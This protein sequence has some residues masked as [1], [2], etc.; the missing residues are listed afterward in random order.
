MGENTQCFRRLKPALD[1]NGMLTP[2]LK[3]WGYCQTSATRTKNDHLFSRFQALRSEL[4]SQ[5]IQRVSFADPR[6]LA[7]DSITQTFVER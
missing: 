7:E 4:L 1:S 5:K 6:Q 3:H 2:A